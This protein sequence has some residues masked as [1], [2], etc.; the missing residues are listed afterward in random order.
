MKLY[1]PRYYLQFKCIADAC[2]HSCCVGWEID[3]DGETMKKYSLLKD[4]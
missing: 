1:A 2:R 3:V 4:G